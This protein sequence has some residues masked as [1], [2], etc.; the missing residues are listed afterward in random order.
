[1][2]RVIDPEDLASGDVDEETARYAHDRGMVDDQWLADYYQTTVDELRAGL[3]APSSSRRLSQVVNTG[4]VNTLNITQEEL[5]SMLEKAREEAR[6]EHEENRAAFE[7]SRR[8]EAD[9]GDEEFRVVDRDEW[10]MD[11]EGGGAYEDGWNNREREA[12]LARRGLSVDGKK[13]DLV[14]RLKRADAGTLEDE[15]YAEA[16][17]PEE[18]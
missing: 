14:A 3:M 17:E 7:E 6:A 10:N 2:A 5:D 4:D 1:M 13:E 12:E 9:G 18:E 8:R 15:D 11:E 16:E